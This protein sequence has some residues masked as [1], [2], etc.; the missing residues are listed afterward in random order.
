MKITDFPKITYAFSN[1]GDGNMSAV[2]GDPSEAIENRKKFLSKLG[3]NI[4]SAVIPSQT[5]SDKV[6][7]VTLKDK[8][9]GATEKSTIKADCLITNQKGITLFLL[10]A[11]CHTISLFDPTNNVIGLVH[12]GWIGLDKEI[13]PKA[14]SRLTKEYN[15][16]PKDLIALLSPSIGPCCYKGFES[17]KQINDLRW[18]PYIFQEG[19]TFGLDLWRFAED[20]LIESGIKKENIY[21]PQICTFHNNDYFSHRR[22]MQTNEPDYRFATVIGLKS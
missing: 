9:I 16:N 11:D 8:G 18:Q 3:I 5:H 17:I 21:N 12:A 19:K 7:T 14:I 2:K 22:A 1:S 10:T 15:S 4:N 6:Y 20:Q 13:I